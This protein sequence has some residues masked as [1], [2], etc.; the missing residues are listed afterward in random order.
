M[1]RLQCLSEFL[2]FL[3]IKRNA[4]MNNIN[5]LLN[6]QDSTI[7]MYEK[8]DKEIGELISYDNKIKKTEEFINSIKREEEA[9][10][11]EKK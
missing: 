2:S 3:I 4:H 6:N 1:S 8:L 10:R 11:K 7:D 5:S 9:L